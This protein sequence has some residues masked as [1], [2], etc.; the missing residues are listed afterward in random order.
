MNDDIWRRDEV[1]SPCVKVCVI[2]PE[3]RICAG[4]YRT[5]DEIATWTRMG[6][7]ERARV[8][9]ELPGRGALVKVRRGGRRARLGAQRNG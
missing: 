5:I 9:A 2:H 3:T 1:E 4:C 8:M 7:E 6:A